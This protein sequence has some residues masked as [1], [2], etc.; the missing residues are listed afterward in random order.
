MSRKRKQKIIYISPEETVIHKTV[1]KEKASQYAK[2]M[3]KGDIFPPVKA[4]RKHFGDLWT[5]TDGAH[6]V[7]ACMILNIP[8]RIETKSKIYYLEEI[9]YA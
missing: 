6:R 4:Y 1:Q 9:E 5:V 3:L 8:V 7:T 2:A